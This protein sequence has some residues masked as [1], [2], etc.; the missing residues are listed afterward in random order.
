MGWWWSSSSPSSKTEP[1]IISSSDSTQ[2][3]PENSGAPP[4]QPRT[5]TREERADAELRQLLASLE[6]DINKGS[7]ASQESPSSAESPEST[8]SPPSSIAPESL[9]PDTMSCRS[10]F[11]YAF[12]CQSFGGQFV[13]VYRYGE[14]R[15]CSE[16]W[17]NFW[18]CMKTRTWS[19]GARKKAVRD[20]YRK[21]AIKYKTGPSS[22]DVWDLRTEPVRNAF[23][24]DFAA[25]EKE[26]QAEEE[27][28]GAGV[29]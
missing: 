5:L 1:Q 18:L 7:E 27:A 17:D 3:A 8:S 19:D 14:L 28:Q 29:A 15:S 25:L 9:Y 23:E 21:K 10:A 12:F 20:H 2:P 6:G 11:D 24:G 16:H 4:S 13:N 26:M 22:E